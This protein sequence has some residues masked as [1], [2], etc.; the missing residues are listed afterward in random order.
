[1]DVSSNPLIINAA[2]V[3][4]AAITVWLG[5]L[6][7]INI[8][9]TNYTVSTDNATVN[10]ANGKLFAYLSAASDLETVKTNN[11]GWA[12]GLIIPI[13][14]ITNGTVRIYKK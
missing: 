6:H 4:A 13:H 14:G 10:Q 8:E 2:D 12:D 1:M 11:I 5:K 9:F 7:V 3:A